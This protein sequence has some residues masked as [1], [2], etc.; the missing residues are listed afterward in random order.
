MLVRCRTCRLER[1]FDRKVLTGMLIGAGGSTVWRELPRQLPCPCGSTDVRVVAMP[2]A[3]TLRSYEQR[4]IDRALK[5]LDIAAYASRTEPVATPAV[6]LAL[7]VLRPYVT[8]RAGLLAFWERAGQPTGTPWESC[9]QPYYVIAKA[10]RDRGW[11]A[12]V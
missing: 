3:G 10:L 6:Q 4:L 5:V 7:Y 2:Y 11:D 1:R 9:R 12:Q 8:D